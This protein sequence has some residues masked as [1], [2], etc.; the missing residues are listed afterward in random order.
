MKDKHERL[1]I[2]HKVRVRMEF[3]AVPAPD[4]KAV[5]LTVDKK[6]T[7]LKV[8]MKER[9]GAAGQTTYEDW[10]LLVANTACEEGGSRVA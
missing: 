8:L 6:I 1:P 9:F 7:M 5:G 4:R 10:L 3:S 2:P